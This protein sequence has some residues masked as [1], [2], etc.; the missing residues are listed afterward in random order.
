[1]DEDGD[2]DQDGD[3]VD[4]DQDE[5][6]GD[7]DQDGDEGDCDGRGRICQHNAESNYQNKSRLNDTKDS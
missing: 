6:E 2:G 5:D 3:E 4:G 7:W 1:M